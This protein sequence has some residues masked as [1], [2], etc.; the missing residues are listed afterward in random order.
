MSY[1][2]GG[3]WQD[4]DQVCAL[5][6]SDRHLGHL[7]RSDRWY[8]YDATRLDES[9]RGFTCLGA[10]SDL[11]SAKRILE[12]AVWAGHSNHAVQ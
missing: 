4:S 7:I 5:T 1:L 10:F 2:F 11:E 6:D 12:L 8:A 9:S 3:L